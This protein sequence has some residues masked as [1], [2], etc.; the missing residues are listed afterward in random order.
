MKTPTTKPA[1]TTPGFDSEYD[2]VM[3][4]VSLDFTIAADGQIV[5][6]DAPVAEK[7]GV[8]HLN[9]ESYRAR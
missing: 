7:T 5:R 3:A 1:R 2:A 6:R 8:G 4:G 9:G